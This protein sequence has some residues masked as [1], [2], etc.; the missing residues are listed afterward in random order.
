MFPA[1]VAA[2]STTR[3]PLLTAVSTVPNSSQPYKVTESL[4][5]GVY[6]ITCVSST[7]AQLTF[8]LSDNTLFKTQTSSGT[9]QITM[10]LPASAYYIKTNT[11]TNIN[12]TVTQ[13]SFSPVTSQITAGSLETLT[14]SGTYTSTGMRWVVLFGGGYPGGGGGPGYPGSGGSSGKMIES[15]FYCGGSVAYTVGAGN[16]GTSTFGTLSS[17]AA[18]YSQAGQGGSISPTYTFVKTGSTGGGGGGSPYFA[19]GGGNGQIGTGGGGPGGYLEGPG[20][21]GTGYAAG[22]GQCGFGGGSGG[23]GSQGVIYLVASN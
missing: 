11:G 17:D 6:T 21:P 10:S 20:Q 7:V 15:P 5:G 14:T 8:L 9:V 16:G 2:T 1:P 4:S 3:S 18:G 23:S 22:G 19:S 13:N 12:V